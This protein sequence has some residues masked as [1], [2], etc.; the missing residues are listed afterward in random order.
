[1]I[2][3]SKHLSNE[4]IKNQKKKKKKK[5]NTELTRKIR[6]RSGVYRVFPI[7]PSGI[8]SHEIK[9]QGNKEKGNWHY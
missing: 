6:I 7:S 3:I 8:T 9:N 5:K 2:T 1:M 4:E